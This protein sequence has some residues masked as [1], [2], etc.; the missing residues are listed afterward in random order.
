MK[1]KT[2]TVIGANGTM[3]SNICG[4]FA[5]F[6]NAKVFMV[7]R[8][9]EKSKKA[10]LK[11]VKSVRADSITTNLIPVDYSMIDKCIKESDLVYESVSEKLDIKCDILKQITK[12]LNSRTVVC[13]GTSGLSITTLSEIL[14]EQLRSNYLGIHMYNPPYNMTLCEVIPT[15]YSNRQ[16][17][18]DVK[19]YLSDVLFRTV[20]EV[21][22]YPAFI[23]NRIGFYFINSALQ[24]AEKS[25]Y[26]GG[27]DYVD[28]LLGSY[29]GRDMAPLITSD[30]VGLDVH[31]AI[32]DNIYYNTKDFVHESFVLPDFAQDM[33]NRSKLG[34]KTNGGLY[35]I[36]YHDNGSKH[37]TVYDIITG[38]YRDKID[39][40]FQFAEQMINYFRIGEYKLAFEILINNRS[41]EAETCLEFLLRY[42]VYSLYI[43][44]NISNDISS[45]DDVMATGYNWCPP[46]ALIDAFSTVTNFSKLLKERLPDSVYKEIESKNI[47]MDVKPSKYDYRLF[48]K[49]NK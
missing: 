46:L 30:F 43:S 24:F 18:N 33:I 17:I 32:V 14:P 47:F 6:G 34:R 9:I 20:V 39:Y 36:E 37:I 4:I 15:Q 35:K 8:D 1:I 11:A 48:F 5:S 26:S 16:L 29:T 41:V 3:G 40:D 22:D 45:A 27:I 13:S 10:M 28:A 23:G 7:S 31:K 21:K 19:N 12:N 25:K 38:V 49:S 44:I 42:I 2:V